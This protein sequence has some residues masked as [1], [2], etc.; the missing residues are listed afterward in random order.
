MQGLGLLVI[1]VLL[2]LGPAGSWGGSR[3]QFLLHLVFDLVLCPVHRVAGNDLLP[4]RQPRAAAPV[5]QLRQGPS[6]STTRSCNSCGEELE[7]P[8]VA[9]APEAMMP[10]AGLV[11]RGRGRP[12]RS[13]TRHA[14]SDKAAWARWIWQQTLDAERASGD[15]SPRL[16][17][18]C[19]VVHA[20]RGERSWGHLPG[21]LLEGRAIQTHSTPAPR[22]RRLGRQARGNTGYTGFS[23]LGAPFVNAGA[24]EGEGRNA[25][26]RRPDG[27]PQSRRVSMCVFGLPGGANL[28][29]YDAFYDAGIRHHPRPPCEAGGGHAAEGYAK[30]TGRVGVSLG[31]SGPGATNLVTPI[32]DAMMDS[33]PVVFPSPARCRTEPAGHRRLSGGRHDRHHHADRRSTAS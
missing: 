4:L 14:E 32:C 11:G 23:R 12:T 21:C 31:T 25:C 7:F 24:F 6:S 9:I 18:F 29:T 19:H 2:R 27:M 10:P 8:D 5:P 1:P 26:S 13:L 28:P 22:A 15:R 3:S 33:V 16:S 17:P 20:D 30:A